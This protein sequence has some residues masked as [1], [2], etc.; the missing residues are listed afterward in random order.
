MTRI[1]N[2]KQVAGGHG[3][4]RLRDAAALHSIAQIDLETMASVKLT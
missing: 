3:I 2:S 1:G 4:G